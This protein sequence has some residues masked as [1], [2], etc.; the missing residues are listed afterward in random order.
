MTEQVGESTE[1]TNRPRERVPVSGGILVYA[2]ER[3]HRA[4]LGRSVRVSREL[5]DFERVTAR[6]ELAGA[7]A[8]RGH[9]RGAAYRLSEPDEQD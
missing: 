7:L 2:V 8:A 3:E 9:A 1:S 5:V 4:H 6:S